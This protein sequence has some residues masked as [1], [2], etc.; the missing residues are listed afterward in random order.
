M[1]DVFSKE[2]RSQVMSR[3]RS[4]NTRPE[5]LVRKHLFAHGFRY[6]LHDS[7]L[8]SKPDIVLPKYKTIVF[9]HGC[10]WHGHTCKYAQVPKS[11]TAFWVDKINRNKNISLINVEKLENLGW[12]VIIIWECELSKKRREKTLNDLELTIRMPLG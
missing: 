8:P 1:A 2:K 10:F 9:I 3:I 11:N 6:R 4:R 7:K 12:R 5:I